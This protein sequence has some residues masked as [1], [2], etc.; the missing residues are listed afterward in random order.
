L[1]HVKRTAIKRD[2]IAPVLQTRN[3]LCA[4]NTARVAHETHVPN[5]LIR[6][7]CASLAVQQYR[8]HGL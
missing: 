5:N 4:A 1:A 7:N 2:E 6:A 3:K 8:D